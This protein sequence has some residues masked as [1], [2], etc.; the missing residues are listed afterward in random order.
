MSILC[1]LRFFAGYSHSVKR[2]LVSFDPSITS[3]VIFGT[4]K[5]AT[6]R[7]SPA[8][9]LSVFFTYGLSLGNDEPI[10]EGE[11]ELAG[12]RINFHVN[13]SRLSV[14]GHIGRFISENVLVLDAV[15]ESGR[16][17]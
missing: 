14:L 1:F 11:F 16:N 3:T 10:F 9:S 2:P 7:H 6:R 12:G 4:P 15:A 17:A 13:L 8:R 5:K